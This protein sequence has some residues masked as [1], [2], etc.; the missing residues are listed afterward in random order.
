M[1]RGENMSQRSERILKSIQNAKLSYGVLHELTGI[2]KSALQRYATGETEK[3]PIDRLEMIAKATGVSVEYLM[4]WDTKESTFQVPPGFQ[5]LPET[6][7]LPRVGQ[8]ACGEPILAEQNIEDYDRV[9]TEWG[10]QF[11]LICAG[12]S[13]VPRIQDGDVVAIRK[14]P[15]VENGEIAAVRIGDEATLKHVYYSPDKLILQPEN[16]AFPPIVLIG[17][18]MN[19]AIIEGKAVGLCR[20][21]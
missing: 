20:K 4:G 16:P 14:Q 2:P 15:S 1:Q 17:E 13:M 7:L 9:P 3:I 8:I 11:T 19:T 6:E 12:D 21:I 18:E 10:A 5:L